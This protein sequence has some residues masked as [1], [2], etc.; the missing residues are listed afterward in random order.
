MTSRKSRKCWWRWCRWETTSFHSQKGQAPDGTWGGKCQTKWW[1]YVDLVLTLPNPHS[2]NL[3]KWMPPLFDPQYVVPSCSLLGSKPIQ[4]FCNSRG[5]PS[6]KV[7]HS[8]HCPGP[9]HQWVGRKLSD[10]LKKKKKA[11]AT[12]I[13]KALSGRKWKTK[14]NTSAIWW[15][16]SIIKL[17]F[18]VCCIQFTLPSC[19]WRSKSLYYCTHATTCSPFHENRW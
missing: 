5:K 10:S 7:Y 18:N 9:R 12:R 8:H 1:D 2:W 19:S 16:R 3:E 6:W 14:Q 11:T 17:A 15:W 13:R 4:E